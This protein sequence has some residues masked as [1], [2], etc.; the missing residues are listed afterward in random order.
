VC[1]RPLAIA[2]LRAPE[3]EVSAE[4]A[5]PA[6]R[7]IRR[8]PLLLDDRLV[9]ERLAG[10]LPNE[11]ARWA[12]AWLVCWFAALA[13]DERFG[14]ADP[15]DLTLPLDAVALPKGGGDGARQ[16]LVL[17]A[18]A[19]AGIATVHEEAQG[20]RHVRVARLADDVFAEH[21]AALAVDWGAVIARCGAEPAALLVMRAL[22]ELI[23]PVDGVSAVPRRDLVAWTGYQQKQVRVAIRRLLAADLIVADGDVGTTARYRLT[24]RALG[25]PWPTQE[26]PAAPEPTRASR[27][28]PV[29]HAGREGATAATSA[30]DGIHVV[31]GGATVTLAAG[32]SLEIGSGLAARMEV[33]PDG[34][35][36]LVV[37]PSSP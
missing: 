26:A 27:A 11:T 35:P 13:A 6:L 28:Q 34:R 18:L 30:G 36:R 5:R 4:R 15:W 17:Q 8:E 3:R 25:R 19:E 9:A 12:R 1:W 32:A 23:V 29:P 10:A 7:A 2:I 24:P 33:G 31:V 37:G 14:R 16:R 21:P 20:R 22:A